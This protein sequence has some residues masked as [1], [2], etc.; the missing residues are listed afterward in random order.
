MCKVPQWSRVGR[1]KRKGKRRGEGPV[2]SIKG[3]EEEMVVGD[4]I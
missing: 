2:R 1:L 4:H 3:K